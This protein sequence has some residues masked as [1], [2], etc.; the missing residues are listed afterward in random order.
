MTIKAQKPL[1]K[2]VNVDIS[3][4]DDVKCDNCGHDVFVPVFHIKKVSA[5]MSPNGQEIIAPMQVFGCNKCGHI[6]EEFMPR[7]A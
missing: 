5:I 7:E 1:P 2:Q 4:A 3:Q 6:N